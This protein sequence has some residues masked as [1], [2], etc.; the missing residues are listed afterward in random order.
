[1]H[2]RCGGYKGEHTISKQRQTRRLGALEANTR[3]GNMKYAE[4]LI[5]LHDKETMVQGSWQPSWNNVEGEELSCTWS[6]PVSGTASLMALRKGHVWLFYCCEEKLWS[7]KLIKESISLK[8]C[9]QGEPLTV[10]VG[11]KAERRQA[12][13]DCSSSGKGNLISIKDKTWVSIMLKLILKECEN[14]CKKKFK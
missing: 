7:R 8:A 13:R 11:S 4:T 14:K 10:M 12:S 1:M 9:L 3:Q 6:D 2:P 5:S